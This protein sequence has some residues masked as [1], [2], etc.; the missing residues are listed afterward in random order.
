MTRAEKLLAECC[1]LW[2]PPPKE[3]LS[4]WAEANF[5]LS[6]EY[7]AQTGP[8]RLYNFQRGILDSFTDPYTNQI[9][10]MS[11]TQMVKT[12]F[13]Q[14]IVAYV[15]SRDPGPILLAQPTETDAETFSKERVAPMVRDMECL[16]GRVAP[17][18]SRTSANTTLHKVFKGGSLSIVGAQTPG[19]FARRSIRVFL[20]DERDKWK[21]SV[22]KEGDGFSL[23]VK[24]TATFRSRAKIVQVC[25]PTIEGNSQIAEAYEA[26]DQRKPYVPCLHCGE[27]QVLRWENVKWDASLPKEDQPDSAYYQCPSC[28][29]HW[30]DVERWA[31]IERCEW[32]ASKPFNGIAGFWISELYS[33][34]K[35]LSDIVRDFLGKKDNPAELQTFVNT[36]LAE[37]WKE[38]GEAPDYEKLMSRREASYRLG[39]VPEGVLFLTAGVDVQKTWL[40][41]YV[42]GWGRNRQRWLVDRFRIEESPFNGAAW[43]ALT[44][45]LN[46]VYRHPSG[47]DL[48]LSRM[49]VDTGFATQEVYAWAR[50]Q[51]ASR[52]LAVDGRPSG[53]ALVG[54]PSQVDVTVG[55]R[56][57]KH[58]AKLWPVNASMAKSELYG[59]LGK[60]RPEE[61]EP[62]P[63]GWIHFPADLDDEFFKQLTAEQLV[64]RVVKGYRKTEWVKTRERNEALDCANYARAAASVV[65]V[66]RFGEK[67]WRQLE[68][69]L[70]IKPTDAGVAVYADTQ[71]E[72]DT[73]VPAAQ[74]ATP[75]QPTRPPQAYTPRPRRRM[76][77]R[78][79]LI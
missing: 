15:I 22:G 4:E 10:V 32:E 34:W 63:P 38:Q 33:P 64:T 69:L 5:R 78:F 74:P 67:H 24:R 21:G 52:V 28:Q 35:K 71:A 18:K 47:A 17:E 46:R 65:G 41:G 44:E 50:Q 11:A 27:F 40:E 75:S 43:D 70:G 55:G 56:K 1:R 20:A 45:Q 54:S 76:A 48:M 79:S 72:P 73:T 7:S 9:V 16:R 53:A 39:Q 57:V 31:A 8:L 68:A 26:S 3:T 62:F 51:G 61:G 25:S 77:A 6:P 23:G 14:C 2:A 59:L 29:A 19:N 37:T 36:S 42:W 12:L 49:A 13:L 30:T 58:G 60:E 66:D